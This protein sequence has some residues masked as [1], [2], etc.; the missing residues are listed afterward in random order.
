MTTPTPVLIEAL[1]ALSRDEADKA[2][3]HDLRQAAARLSELQA[4][5][6]RLNGELKTASAKNFEIVARHAALTDKLRDALKPFA[7]Y[8]TI[9]EQRMAEQFGLRVG[10]RQNIHGEPDTGEI[11]VGHLR[12]ARA[13][14]SPQTEATGG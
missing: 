3:A 12:T 1:R 4:E 5:V 6:G 14:L 13:S 7:D 8:A 10:N 11:T 9:Y 2:A